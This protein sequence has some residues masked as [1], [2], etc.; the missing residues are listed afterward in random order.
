MKKCE[1]TISKNYVPD[2]GVV[3]AVRELFQ[4]AL[5]Q[6][7]VN[8]TNNM[9]FDYDESAQIL[10]IGNK[11]STLEVSSLLLGQTTKADNEDTI[12]QFGEGYKIAMLV[13]LRE[14]LGVTFYNWGKKEVWR[15]RFVNSRKYQQ[16]I[17]TVFIEKH[18]WDSVPEN[19]LS[20]EI[21]GVTAEMYSRIVKS[22]LHLQEIKD[23]H[24][25]E[26][27]GRILLDEEF[28]GRI[29]VNGLYVMKYDLDYGYDFKPSHIQLK[30][31]RSAI[32]SF[33]VKW[34]TS[35]MWSK[36][37]N[38]DIANMII[39]DSKDVV[40]VGRLSSMTMESKEDIFKLFSDTNGGN[41]VP[42]K[43][44]MSIESFMED[45]CK[46]TP[47]IV[48][49]SLFEIISTSDTYKERLELLKEVRNYTVSE[50][51]SKWMIALSEECYVSTESKEEFELLVKEVAY[52]EASVIE[53]ESV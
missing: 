14:G 30:R 3:E 1:L 8:P 41:A 36:V 19:S 39:E 51:L 6:Q 31:D 11:E 52:I 40:F 16:E 25:V 15:P 33:D 42:L 46:A 13:L 37:E 7:T 10:K 50:K 32:D 29:Y 44:G 18:F 20:I 21:K 12:G 27:Y 26:S 43:K 34:T 49:D 23:V 17:L 48:S 4:N 22:N 5:D 38:S 2:W 9:F 28:K 35:V 45:H 53:S 47:I 24:N